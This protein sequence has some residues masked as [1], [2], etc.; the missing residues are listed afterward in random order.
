M[1]TVLQSY[2]QSFIELIYPQIC[3]AC[4]EH[5]GRFDNSICADCIQELPYTNDQPRANYLANQL[6]ALQPLDGVVTLCFLNKGNKPEALIHHLK[7][8][9]RRDIGEEMGGILGK[10][11]QNFIADYDLLMPV[12]LHQ[13]KLN[14]R[15][16]NQAT[17]IA[18]GV[19]YVVKIPCIS[20]VLTRKKHTESQTRKSRIQRFENVSNAFTVANKE[21][22]K[23]KKI[24]LIDDVITTGSTAI[25]CAE[26]LFA[27]GAEKVFIA[28]LAK[29][30]LF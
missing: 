13:K 5:L 17:S 6:L 30:D 12:P 29:A 20:K 25:T 9:N 2:F 21:W 4:G 22:V 15:G 24:V 8:S 14:Q 27:N 19:S 16:Y 18:T 23:G 1:I 7:Y 28:A 10:K 3:V 11:I 26:T